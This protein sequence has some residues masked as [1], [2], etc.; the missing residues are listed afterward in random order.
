MK[1]KLGVN[2]IVDKELDKLKALSDFD[3]TCQF[4]GF[5][6]KKYQEVL[7]ING[8]HAVACSF[9]AQS[10]NL[11][12]CAE[13]RAGYLI[14]LPEL[15][16]AQLNNLLRAI[17][18]VRTSTNASNAN[19][20]RKLF[21]ALSSRRKI[22]S[23]IL[24][25]DDPYMLGK[26]I[27]SFMNNREKSQIEEKLDGIRLFSLDK[28]ISIEDGME[29]NEFPQILNYWKTDVE[30]LN[31]KCTEWESLIEEVSLNKENDTKKVKP[32]FRKDI[33]SK[34]VEKSLSNNLFDTGLES[35]LNSTK[36]EE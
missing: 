34:D 26:I 20:A 17:Y 7:D 9:C 32:V 4:C 31:K 29:F 15:T 18:V 33:S 6:S 27:D 10:L 23:L 2:A 13:R 12:A 1:L 11:L 14:Y 21:D 35:F 28:K 8:H 24:G 3:Y 30:F 36:E 22:A 25:T 19:K 5:K 16:Q